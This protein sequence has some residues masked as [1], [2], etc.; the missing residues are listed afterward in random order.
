[1]AC[2]TKNSTHSDQQGTRIPCLDVGMLADHLSAPIRVCRIDPAQVGA[3]G[4]ATVRADRVDERR[5]TVN[6]RRAAGV[7][8]RLQ[9]PLPR[10]E[11]ARR[12][13]HRCRLRKRAAQA[14]LR[15]TCSRWGVLEGEVPIAA[16]LQ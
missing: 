7:V 10:A 13:G 12:G 15:A 4:R 1:M 2:G 9:Q 6:E 11:R 16:A 14:A 3:E 8:L 5:A